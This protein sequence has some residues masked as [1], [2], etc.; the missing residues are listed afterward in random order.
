MSNVSHLRPAWQKGQSGNPSGSNMTPE[1]RAQLHAA[2]R[3]CAENAE[4][5]ITTLLEIMAH[6]SE[7]GRLRAA[8]EL[9]DRAGLKPVALD[10]QTVEQDAD[11]ATRTVRVEFVRPHAS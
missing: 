9:L 4:K 10:V 11:G 2:R 3:L 1:T 8:S 5:A 7:P 6:G